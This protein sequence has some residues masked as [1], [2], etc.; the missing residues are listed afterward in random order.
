MTDE[1]YTHVDLTKNWALHSHGIEWTYIVKVK[2]LR[3]IQEKEPNVGMV[4][5]FDGNPTFIIPK[6]KLPAAILSKYTGIAVDKLVGVEEVIEL[7][8][9]PRPDLPKPTVNQW[10]EA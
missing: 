10:G 9:K 3:P 5:F 2:L 6:D 7:T 8:L 4:A 1:Q